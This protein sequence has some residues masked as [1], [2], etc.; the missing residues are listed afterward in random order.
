MI[1]EIEGSLLPGD[2]LELLGGARKRGEPVP[3]TYTVPEPS[4]P[5]YHRIED[6]VSDEVRALIEADRRKHG[7]G[8][9]GDWD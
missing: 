8:W 1:E 7:P 2:E 9:E 4:E 6:L 3:D 5:F